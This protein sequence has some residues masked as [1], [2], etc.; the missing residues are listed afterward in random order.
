M[1]LFESGR[2]YRAALFLFWSSRLVAL[3]DVDVR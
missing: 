3:S 2:D 1:F